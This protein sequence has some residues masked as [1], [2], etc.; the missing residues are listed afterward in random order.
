MDAV[1]LERFT[2]NLHLCHVTKFT[3]NL[4][5]PVIATLKSVDSR[6]KNFLSCFYL[7]MFYFE[8]FSPWIWRLPIHVSRKSDYTSIYIWFPKQAS[9]LVWFDCYFCPAS[10]SFKSGS[11]CLIPPYYLRYR[12]H[13][14]LGH[15][16][17]RR[18]KVAGSN[19]CGVRLFDHLRYTFSCTGFGV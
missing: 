6:H 5:F 8:N 12:R 7:L 14:Y 2:A 9:C 3:L 11:G 18:T 13:Y 17:D 19:G 16:S 1:T 15:C 4:L 10:F